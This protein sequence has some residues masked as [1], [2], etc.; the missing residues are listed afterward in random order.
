[1][2]DE[3]LRGIVCIMVWSISCAVLAV[4]GA[5]ADMLGGTYHSSME[6]TVNDGHTQTALIAAPT[7]SRGL[8]LHWV[9]LEAEDHRTALVTPRLVW[10]SRGTF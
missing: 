1:M 8:E 5:L 6:G 10:P 4:F 7:H 9:F 3:I 2:N